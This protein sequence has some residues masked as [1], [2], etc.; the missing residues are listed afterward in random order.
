MALKPGTKEYNQWRQK[1]FN[2]NIKVPQSA[3]DKLMAGKTPSNNIKKYAGTN[4]KVMREAMNRFYGKGW[5][6]KAPGASTGK[7]P[8]PA[9]GKPLAPTRPT[10]PNT[11]K[12]I[13]GPNMRQSFGAAKKSNSDKKGAPVIR[14]NN[15]LPEGA[16]RLG[17]TYKGV[18]DLNTRIN[19]SP[20]VR[21]AN[22]ASADKFWTGKGSK[23][24]LNKATAAQ[25][26]T[27]MRTIQRQQ[28]AI[29]KQQAAGEMTK[30]QA[31]KA[32]MQ[33]YND[34]SGKLYAKVVNKGAKA[35]KAAQV[36]STASKGSRAVSGVKVASKAI[37]PVTRIM[38]RF[39]GPIGVIATGAEAVRLGT[40]G[41]GQREY[42]DMRRAIDNLI[43]GKT[44]DGKPIPQG[45]MYTLA[46]DEARKKALAAKKNLN[47]KGKK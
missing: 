22:M 14:G 16:M 42:M 9:G 46:Y 8:K 23:A 39:A 3:I 26:A 17:L 40:T 27:A 11:G 45:T 28:A 47:K 7:G 1:N 5:E 24:I 33:A 38:G 25:R 34:V 35:T 10:N 41:Q 29:W 36:A 15:R 2:L 4:D 30:A 21:G 13:G 19:N 31:R 12:A 32:A 43:A 20:S 37:K 6:K 18:N 44:A